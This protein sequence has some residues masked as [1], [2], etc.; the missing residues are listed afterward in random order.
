MHMWHYPWVGI[1]NKWSQIMKPALY[2]YLVPFIMHY[3]VCLFS[4]QESPG[5]D[6]RKHTGLLCSEIPL[7]PLVLYSVSDIRYLLAY[8][9]GCSVAYCFLDGILSV[10][11]KHSHPTTRVT[12]DRTWTLIM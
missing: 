5:S 10:S 1:G 8:C 7:F 4:P 6:E 12:I 3:R 2:L 11:H 9:G